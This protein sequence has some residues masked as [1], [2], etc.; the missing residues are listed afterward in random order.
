MPTGFVLQ[1][2]EILHSKSI[3]LITTGTTGEKAIRAGFEVKALL[4]GP[5]GGMH[6]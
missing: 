4:Y 3:K 1:Y 2:Q 5:L 6:K